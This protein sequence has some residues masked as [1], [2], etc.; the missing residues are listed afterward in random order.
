MLTHHPKLPD[1]SFRT[2]EMVYDSTTGTVTELPKGFG[3]TWVWVTKESWDVAAPEPHG[4]VETRSAPL[5]P[6]R[7]LT[8]G[9]IG[10]VGPDSQIVAALSQ[11]LG[12]TRFARLLPIEDRLKRD[13]YAEICR[14]ER[15][16]VRKLRDAL[17]PKPISGELRV[18]DADRI[19]GRFTV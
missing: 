12:W 13:F 7:P 10:G 1:G 19:V 6:L 3:H 2:A 14:A 18:R 9:A 5:L 17:L 16:S 8:H 15:W 4:S 11:Q